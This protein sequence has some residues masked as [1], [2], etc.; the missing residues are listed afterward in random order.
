MRFDT[1]SADDVV[2][3]HESVMNGGGWTE[4][5]IRI[6]T[7]DQLVETRMTQEQAKA[8]ALHLMTL[9]KR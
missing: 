9:A 5:V 1:C 8:L 6:D 7:G 3:A 4:V 2:E